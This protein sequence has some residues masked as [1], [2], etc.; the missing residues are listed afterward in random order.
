[1]SEDD[2]WEC[3]TIIHATAIMLGTYLLNRVILLILAISN[4]SFSYLTPFR[5]NVANNMY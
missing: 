3:G 5:G 2:W 1:M 4:G